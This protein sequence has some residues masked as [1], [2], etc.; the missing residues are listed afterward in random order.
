MENKWYC[1]GD[2]LS[3]KITLDLA[4]LCIRF[5]ITASWK[6]TLNFWGFS[7]KNKQVVRLQMNW[8]GEIRGWVKDCLQWSNMP[9]MQ[10]KEQC[11]ED[12]YFFWWQV[13]CLL[14]KSQ[15]YWL[16]WP[17]CQMQLFWQLGVCL[18]VESVRSRQLTALPSRHLLCENVKDPAEWAPGHAATSSLGIQMAASRCGIWP[19]LWTW[20]IRVKTKVSCIMPG[21]WGG[22]FSV[23]TRAWL[24]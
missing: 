3:L 12:W 17:N 1:G 9:V 23:L 6:Q 14:R 20:L 16:Y 15:Q 22:S 7:N 8:R 18:S 4:S 5:L 13:W 24:Q 2:K 10:G 11:L 21:L 19:Q